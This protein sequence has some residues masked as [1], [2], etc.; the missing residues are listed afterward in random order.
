MSLSTAPLRVWGRRQNLNTHHGRNFELPGGRAGRNPFSKKDA[1][2]MKTS[3]TCTGL[4]LALI[5]AVSLL[6][7]P[8]MF[9]DRQTSARISK[10]QSDVR[11]I[12]PSTSRLT[13]EQ[14]REAYGQIEMGFEASSEQTG[15]GVNF[16]ARGAGYTLFLK[17]TEAVFVL[18]RNG[19]RA[20]AQLP[21]VESSAEKALQAG[22]SNGDGGSAATL[23]APPKVLRLKLAG[24]DKTAVVKGA[25][26][27]PGKVNYFIGDDSAKWRANVSTFG[28]VRYAQ[29]YQGVDVVYYGNQ[30]QLEYDFII[31]PGSDARA[32]KLQ[33]DGA[34]K[35]EVDAA[36]DLLLALGESVIR[37]PKPLM[38]QEVSGERRAVDGGYAVNAAGQVGFAVGDYDAQRPLIIDPVLV[39]STYLGGS[40]VDEGNDIAVDSAG[41]AYICGITNSTNFPTAN[42]IQGTFNP[43]INP[44]LVSRDGFV[45]KL[46][47]AGTALVYSTY[48]GGN[49]D[50]RCNKIAVDASGNAYVAGETGSTNFPTANA[51]QSTYGGG[52]SDGYIAKLNA[53]GSAFVYSTYLGG[54][55]FDAAHALTIDSTGSVYATGRTTS[56]TFPVVNPIQGTY[57]GG[58]GADAFVTKINAAGTALVYSTYLGGN[59]GTTGGFTAGFSI[60]VDSTGSAYLTGQ[61]RA[62]NFPTANAIQSTFGGGF[63]DGDAFVTK[64][65]AAGTA[66]VYSTYL[67]GSDNDIG[68][69]IALDSAGNAYVTGVANSANFPTA[70]AFQSTLKGTSDAFVTKL[71]AAGTAFIYSTYLGGTTNESG[72]AIAVDSAGNAYVA[73]G[74]SSTDFPLVNP[75]QGT[76]AGLVDI[77]LTK[78]NAG[79]SALTY[80]TYF[81]GSGND[82]ALAVAVDS[83]NSM[84]IAGRTSS[85]NYPTLNPIQSANGGGGNND[86]FITKISD[87]PP[88][89]FQ[90]SQ[91]TYPVQEDVT[92]VSFTV[93]RTG[94]TSAGATVDYA[95]ADGTASERSDYTT[96]LGTIRFAAG[97]TA[98]TVPVLINED[99][100][101]EGMEA[102]TVTLSNPT[103]GTSIGTPATATIQIL[104]DGSEPAANAIDDSTIFVGTHYHDFLNRQ[105][106]S[107]GLAFWV[108]EIESCGANAPC[109]EVKRIN[110]SAAFFLS[111]EFQQTGYFV[112]RVYKSAFG[113]TSG[114]PAYRPFLRDTQEI[115]RGVV[116][117]SP[118][119]DALLEAN[120]Q[121]FATAF[122]QRSDFQAAHGSQTADQYVDSLFANAGATPTAPERASAITAFGSG[123]TAG[124]T[125]ALR[126]IIESGSVFNKLY[127]PSFVL[128][129]YFGYLRR[130]PNDAPDGNFSGYD[131]WLAKM[132]QFSL[133]G[134]D[135]RNEQVALGR[136]QRAEMVKAFIISGEYRGRFGP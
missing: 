116:I 89:T 35:V 32:I 75:N 110:V 132:N 64:L 52:F 94:N 36:G 42:A 130:N 60:K 80:S 131:F 95:T 101:V 10:V 66:L 57:S 39:Y 5:C 29:V 115:G 65:N 108:N 4:T 118:G 73:G 93:T 98:A 62:T 61:T 92:S 20:K 84:Y 103:G 69:E 102:F 40:D 63:P 124:R 11:P 53:A 129:Q 6:S 48:L 23:H 44:S 59:A 128:M 8:A 125:A 113:S 1:H 106:D 119:A 24:A 7:I 43:P 37:Q 22:R 104:D 47:A 15:S 72:N 14:A 83:A 31:A 33:F 112:I 114:N 38:Y 3:Y 28:S 19:G 96:A 41:N 134:E 88:T 67:G 50:D 68:N 70:N 74:T 90:F 25:D 82:T 97:E 17:S 13:A 109:R 79:G 107:A 71:N 49:A 91:S 54:D 55:V 105:S 51:F 87:P 81:G 133:T 46:N 77:F 136:V 16:L 117:G 127:N 99:S 26:E 78:F 86:V 126:N 27:L 2:T 9:A 56:S 111:I 30:R 12:K 85:T 122:V 76:F 34:D 120:K 100:R 135:V 18:A 21:P 45:T 123:D 58:P 121:A